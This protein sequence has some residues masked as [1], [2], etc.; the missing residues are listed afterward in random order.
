MQDT[1]AV[2]YDQLKEYFDD[3]DDVTYLSSL[4]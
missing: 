3:S 2:F 1:V 4:S